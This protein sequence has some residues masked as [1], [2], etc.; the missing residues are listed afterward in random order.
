MNQ[1]L[2][3]ETLPSVMCIDSK[4]NRDFAGPWT[5]IMMWLAGLVFVTKQLF[6]LVAVHI[7]HDWMLLLS[8]TRFIEGMLNGSYGNIGSCSFEFC[9]K[10]TS[11]TRSELSL[12]H[13]I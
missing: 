12:C 1:Y 10:Y 8:R 5:V 11:E 3:S 7:N 2:P 9:H 4:Q 13:S 6:S